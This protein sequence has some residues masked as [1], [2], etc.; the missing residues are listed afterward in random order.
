ML[1]CGGGFG[2][3]QRV[4]LVVIGAPLGVPDDNV[5]AP[6]LGQKGAADV[7]RIGTG[8]MW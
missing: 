4:I 1:E 6:Q 2:G 5:T 7:T 3:H 8:V